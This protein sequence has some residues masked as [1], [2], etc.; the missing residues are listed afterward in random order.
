MGVA[1]VRGSRAAALPPKGTN[2]SVFRDRAEWIE[3]LEFKLGPQRGRLAATMDLL[4]DAVIV[5]GTHEAY[6]RAA[7]GSTRPAP[8]LREALRHLEH[9]KELIAG[10]LSDP[11]KPST[12]PGRA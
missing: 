8:D 2:V 10:M 5:L 9:A 7:R 4:T 6:C 3:E 12:P 11:A 1:P